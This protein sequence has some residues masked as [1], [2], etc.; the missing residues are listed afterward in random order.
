MI[1]RTKLEQLQLE[2][3]IVSKFIVVVFPGEAQAYQGTRALKELHDEGSLTLYGVAVVAKDARGSIET[4]EAADS[5]PLG[6]AVGALVGGFIGTLGGPVGV[7][8]GAAGGALIGSLHDLF[9]LGVGEDFLQ[10][11]S[12]ELTPGKTAVIAEVAEYWTVPLDT[13]MD[14][15]GGTV[16]RTWRADFE[17]EQIEK[18]IAAGR[19]E[20]EQLKAEYT[21]AKDEA[22]AKLKARMDRAKADLDKAEARAS[23]KLDALEKETKAKIAALEKQLSDARDDAK[24]EISRRIDALRTDYDRR[25]AKLKQAWQLTKEAL[26]A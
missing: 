5:G 25:S 11:V 1:A 8:A 16:L 10:Q 20:F 26:A 24:Q 4:K 13:R 23:A 17:D 2:E 21:Q 22:K 6:T 12:T 19:V 7:F 14:A 3:V 15:L 18:E 9:N